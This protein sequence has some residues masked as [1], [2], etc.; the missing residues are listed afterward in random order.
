MSSQVDSCPCGTPQLP[1]VSVAAEDGQVW[2]AVLECPMCGFLALGGGSGPI[3][4]L[5]DAAC[6]WNALASDPNIHM[7]RGRRERHCQMG[8]PGQSRQ[9]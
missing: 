7:L 5:T 9:A 6:W 4:S 1:S 8:Q 3:T 2:R